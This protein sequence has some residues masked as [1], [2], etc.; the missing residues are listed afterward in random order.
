[1]YWKEYGVVQQER[2]RA[3]SMVKCKEF[4]VVQRVRCSA[5]GMV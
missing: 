3:G 2:C 1:M 4:G 5:G